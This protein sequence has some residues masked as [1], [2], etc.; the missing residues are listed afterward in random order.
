M[1][2]M[3]ESE[4]RALLD[5]PRICP[6]CEPWVNE[7]QNKFIFSASAG[8][9]SESG[10]REN[11]FVYLRVASNPKTK[12]QIFVF[13]LFLKTTYSSEVVYQL[14]ID[15]RLPLSKH[16][17]DWPHEHMGD[18]RSISKDLVMLSFK[19]ALHHFGK[20]ANITFDPYPSDPTE[21]KLI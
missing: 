10:K 18:L 15:K 2:R 7:P 17:H 6:N 13:S 5:A 1:K 21:F 14:D 9:T 3:P 20:T 11:L 19:D 16:A 8:T 12:T 4:A